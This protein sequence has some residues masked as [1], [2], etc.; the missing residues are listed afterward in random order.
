[1]Q[2]IYGNVTKVMVDAKQGNNL[3]YLPLDKIMQMSAATAGPAGTSGA[4]S[5]ANTGSTAAPSSPAPNSRTRDTERSRTRD[6][7]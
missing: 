7:R 4:T 6:A 1:M 3:L 2:Q 5:P